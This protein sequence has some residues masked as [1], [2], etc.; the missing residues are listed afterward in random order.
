M[1][2]RNLVFLFIVAVVLIAWYTKPDYDDFLAYRDKQTDLPKI[3]PSIEFTDA[4]LFSQVKVVY[5]EPREVDI[6]IQGDKKAA[7]AVPLRT[8]KFIGLFGRFWSTDK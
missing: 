6:K 4:F 8:E 2:F 7:V 5:F 1:K 3:P